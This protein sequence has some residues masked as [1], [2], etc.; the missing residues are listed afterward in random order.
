MAKLSKA[1]KEAIILNRRIED[2]IDAKGNDPEAY[3]A[4]EKALLYQY[5]GYGGLNEETETG[6]GSLYEYYT[7][8]D[9]VVS[10]WRLALKHGF[11]GGNVL[12]PAAGTGRFIVK[13]PKGQY[14]MAFTAIEPS[15]YAKSIIEILNAGVRAYQKYFEELFL[16]DDIL[17]GKISVEENVEPQFDLVI[18]N[19]PYGDIKGT[20][21]GFHFNIGKRLSEKEYSQATDYKQYFI[22]RG[23]DVLKEGGL[24]IY[25]IGTATG[26]NFLSQ[27][28]SKIKDMINERAELIDAYRMPLNLF[29]RTKVQSD[30]VVFKKR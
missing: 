27:K 18:G 11:T 19:P 1:A 4:E 14:P 20:G 6:V 24:L 29:E 13:A 12:E 15:R 30:I 26:T 25:I 21:G 7:P 28:N 5:S 23:L 22:L 16:Y 9:V 17:K 8:D 2:L 3:T 10:M